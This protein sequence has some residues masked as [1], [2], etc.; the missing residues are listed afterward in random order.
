MGGGGGRR[1]AKEREKERTG[2]A[3]NKETAI[4]ISN[5]ILRLGV[6]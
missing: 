5:I 3:L 4:I 6:I 1:K 2:G